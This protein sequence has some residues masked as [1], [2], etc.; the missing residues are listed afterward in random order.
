[1]NKQ[2]RRYNREKWGWND[3]GLIPNNDD[4]INSFEKRNED[5]GRSKRNREGTAKILGWSAIGGTSILIAWLI[6]TMIM[7]IIG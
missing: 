5:Q 1:M 6:V 2:G 3:K 4:L 7:K